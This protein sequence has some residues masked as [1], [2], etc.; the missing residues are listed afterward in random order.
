MQWEDF[1][2]SLTQFSEMSIKN[3]TQTEFYQ[4][5]VCEIYMLV[6]ISLTQHVITVRATHSVDCV[7][8][9]MRWYVV[10]VCGGVIRQ[11]QPLG[12]EEAIK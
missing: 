4:K 3:V 10:W 2:I 7:G 1:A 11:S 12:R 6:W 8:S 5:F 9:R